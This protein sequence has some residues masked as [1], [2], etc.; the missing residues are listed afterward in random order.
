MTNLKDYMK[1]HMG[2]LVP[3]STIKE[4]DLLR[5]RL[6][7]DLAKKAKEENA[8]LRELKRVMFGDVNAFIDLSLE[9]Y[10]VKQGGVK[11]NL[12]LTSFDG[13]YKILVA[14]Q[15]HIVFDERLQAAKALI[16]E[17]FKRWT[18][19]SR[20]EI[21]ALID[22]AFA[23][24][25]QGNINTQRVLSLRKLKIE[26]EQWTRAMSAIADAVTVVGSKSYIRVYERVEGSDKYQQIILDFASV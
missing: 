12:S 26:D 14:I 19:D 20:P 22:N 3:I 4:I 17:C 1:D 11:G 6:V 16:D 18:A 8:V 5:D 25:K 9:K 21:K 23:V 13:C 15:E 2:R 24:D 10:E 7:T